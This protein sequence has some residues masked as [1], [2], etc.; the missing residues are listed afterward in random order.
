[1]GEH[2]SKLIASYSEDEVPIDKLSEMYKSQ[3]GYQLR[4][5]NLGF[6]N[7]VTLLSRFL[8]EQHIM[9]LNNLLF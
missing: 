5:E 3:Y 6:N 8:T 2:I 7:L 9:Q 1:M 4:P